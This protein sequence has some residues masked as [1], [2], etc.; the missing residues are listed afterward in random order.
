MFDTDLV[1]TLSN[2]L[3]KIIHSYKIKMK[4]KY[5]INNQNYWSI[6]LNIGK[7]IKSNYMGQNIKA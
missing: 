1:Q 4:F 2:S 6:R 7:H 5:L 3:H